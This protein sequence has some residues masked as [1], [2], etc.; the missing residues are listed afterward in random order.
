MHMQFH[1]VLIEHHNVEAQNPWHD[2]H[3][4]AKTA[5]HPKQKSGCARTPD[6]RGRLCSIYER[7]HVYA[8]RR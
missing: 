4:I 2:D 7:R 3:G 1:G 5:Q 8:H 6:R